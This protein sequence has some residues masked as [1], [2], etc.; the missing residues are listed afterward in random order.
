MGVS[1][2]VPPAGAGGAIAIDACGGRVNMEWEPQAA[3]TGM[4]QCHFSINF[5]KE[6]DL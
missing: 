1:R 6:A 5:L 2:M 3:V 4:G